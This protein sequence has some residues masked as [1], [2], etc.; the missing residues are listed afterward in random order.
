[1]VQPVSVGVDA[2]SAAFM[3]YTGGI[4]TAPNCGTAINHMMLAVGWGTTTNQQY[5]IL[6]NTWSSSW[7]ENGYIRVAAGGNEGGSGA[8][9]IP[10]Y[11]V[12]N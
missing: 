4:L 6:K 2:S 10:S 1:M 7:G 9:M 5:Y 12:A 3:S 11:G 8:Q